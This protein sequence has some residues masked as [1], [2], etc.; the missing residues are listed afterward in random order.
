MRLNKVMSG[1]FAPPAQDVEAL[2]VAF[3]HGPTDRRFAPGRLAS[4]MCLT[5]IATAMSSG[6][7]L[8][9]TGADITIVGPISGITV[10][11]R[12][13]PTLGDIDDDGLVEALIGKEDG[14]LHYF[15]NNGT[16]DA[17]A[18]GEP[19]PSVLNPVD[20]VEVGT[21]AG[22]TLADVDGDGD[23]DLLIGSGDDGNFSYYKNTGTAANPVF[24]LQTGADD[25]FA[26]I[27]S[28]YG[29][30]AFADVDG[31]GDLDLVIGDYSGELR[32][33]DNDNGTFIEQT[34]AANPFDGINTGGYGVPTFSDLDGDGDLDMVTGSY[35]GSLRYFENTGSK[36][37]PVFTELTGDQNPFASLNT[38]TFSS[39][40]AVDFDGDGDLDIVVGG[41][42]GSVTL[43]RNNSGVA[44]NGFGGPG[45]GGALGLLGLLAF[46]PLFG[47]LARKN[48]T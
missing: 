7:A 18:Y 37:S 38:G 39:P 25:P 1:K 41:G 3:T 21:F 5:M 36:T 30:P 48:R 14:R 46:L 24:E 27:N 28:Y 20:Q 42:D 34:G 11:S 16:T 35:D 13:Y 44:N 23:L 6:A 22:P 17:P 9:Q 19:G 26:A 15:R 40:T 8:A 45:G 2:P 31:D 33:F 29:A 43:I 12:S 32:C 10:T 47:R 4:A